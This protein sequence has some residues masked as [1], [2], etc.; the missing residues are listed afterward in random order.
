MGKARIMVVEDERISA[1]IIKKALQKLGYSVSSVVGSGEQAIIKAK[2]ERPDLVLMDIVLQGEM[3]GIDAAQQIRLQNNIPVIYLSSYSEEELIQR[4]KVTEPY[5]YILKPFKDRELHINIEISLYR[6]QLEQELRKAYAKLKKTLRG[7]I[8]AMSMIAEIGDPFLTG[9]QQRTAQ[10]A[11]AIA[12]QMDLEK[13]QI[14]TIWLA[15]VIHDIGLISIPFELFHKPDRS[16]EEQDLYNT[17]AM[18]GYNLSKPMDFEGPVAEII[19]Q[20][21]ERINGSGYPHG[22]SGEEILLEARILAV[23]DIVETKTSHRPYRPPFE[24]NAVLEEIS[25]ARS[26]LYDEKVL[27]ACL[28]LFKDKRYQTRFPV[29]DLT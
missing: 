16:K 1:E 6:H 27:D 23:A 26:I 21:H 17:H 20:H 14:E 24:L 3:N 7:T 15:A 9:H 18:I 10:L 11:C 28:K 19:L 13:D 8:S 4:A 29:E 25:V 5:A 2:E 22:I 12:K